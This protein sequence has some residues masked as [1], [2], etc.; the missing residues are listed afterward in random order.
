LQ[1]VDF[2]EIKKELNYS[3]EIIGWRVE[4]G[5]IAHGS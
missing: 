1:E 5:E 4:G 2:M 3:H